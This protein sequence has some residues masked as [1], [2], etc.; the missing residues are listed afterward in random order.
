MNSTAGPDHDKEFEVEVLVQG[1]TLGSG[2]GKTKKHAE[3]EA[4]KAAYR[5]LMNAPA[6]E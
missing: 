5:R 6:G 3:Q 4:A 1:N 2:C